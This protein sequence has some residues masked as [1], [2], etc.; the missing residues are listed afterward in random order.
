MATRFP[1][2]QAYL[3]ALPQGAHSYP[4][5]RS[6]AS[7]IRN[8]EESRRLVVEPGE[9]PEPCYEMLR[10]PPPSS[11][12]QPT[13]PFCALMLAYGDAHFPGDDEGFNAWIYGISATLYAKP[14]YRFLMY[15]SSPKRIVAGAASRWH[16]FHQGSSVDMLEHT[17]QSAVFRVNAPAGIFSPVVLKTTA[18]AWEAAIAAAG[19]TSVKSEIVDV[20]GT[21]RLTWK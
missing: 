6:K 4:E 7:L 14:L 20:K 17:D 12:W 15:V 1:R 21:F 11:A 18:V 9:L 10:N 16:T 2:L 5:V 8:M 19:G 3:D 13:V